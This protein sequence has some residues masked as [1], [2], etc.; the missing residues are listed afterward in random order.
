MNILSASHQQLG[1]NDDRCFV[2]NLTLHKNGS[3]AMGVK[4]IVRLCDGDL[5]V[6]DIEDIVPIPEFRSLNDTI[7]FL[8]DAVNGYQ[9]MREALRLQKFDPTAIDFRQVDPHA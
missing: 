5:A 3:I 8:Y 6:E 4:V 7:S 1:E 2:V 9:V